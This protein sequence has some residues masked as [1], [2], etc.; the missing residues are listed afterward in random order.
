MNDEAYTIRVCDNCDMEQVV[1]L[2]AIPGKI[3]EWSDEHVN[4]Y[5]ETLG[6]SINK[7]QLCPDCRED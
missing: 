7:K 2:T 1:P 4:E 6:W 5:L 3:G